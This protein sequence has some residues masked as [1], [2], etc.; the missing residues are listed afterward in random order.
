MAR[1]LFTLAFASA[2]AA[3]CSPANPPQSGA[4]PPPPVTAASPPAPE[5]APPSATSAAPSS[6]PSTPPATSAAPASAP[7]APPAPAPSAP[8][9][10]SAPP[11]PTFREVTI[12]AETA[13]ALTLVTPIASNTSQVE[14]QVRA[15]LTNAIVID[16]TTV[17]PAGAEVVGSVL[18][19]KESGRVKGRASLAVRFDRLTVRGESHKIQ[20]ARI[21][22]EAA[23]STKKDVR[24]GAIGAGAGAIVGGIAGGGTGA[25]IGAGVGGAATVLA[26]KG[27]E[28]QLAAG[29]AL[30][31][32]LVAPLRVEVR[33]TPR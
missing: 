29:T 27:N 17:V 5:S 19:V 2:L 31:T 33:I 25:A 10:P 24:R 28:V 11:A 30:S 12:P 22:T 14:D 23:S 9:A 32:R 8:A 7:S 4:V 18:E 20:T 3:G 26:T 1:L 16:G 15:T 13:I 6:T 21:A